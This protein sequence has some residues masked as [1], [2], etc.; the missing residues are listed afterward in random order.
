MRKAL[1]SASQRTILGQLLGLADSD[2]LAVQHLSRSARLTP[3]QLGGLLQL[4]SGGTTALIQRLERHGYVR[5]EPHPTDRRSSLL[6]L[7]PEIAARAAESLS[8]LV[9]EMDRLASALSAE[10]RTIVGEFLAAV[11]DAGERHADTLLRHAREGAGHDHGV[12]TPE[13]WA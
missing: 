10:E 2:V 1:A 5:R 3:G 6:S 4:T 11:A 12:A 9:D 7:A 13:L 8:P